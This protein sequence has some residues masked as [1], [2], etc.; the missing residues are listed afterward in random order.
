MKG[1]CPSS[2]IMSTSESSLRFCACLLFKLLL[3]KG[4]RH[5]MKKLIPLGQYGYAL[6]KNSESYD[7]A[8]EM[9]IEML[10]IESP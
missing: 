9:S 1:A 2:P 5:R 6:Y 4:V 8:R 10:P 7:Y 3:F